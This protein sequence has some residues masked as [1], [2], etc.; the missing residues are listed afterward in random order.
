MKF[1]GE[2]FVPGIT[3]Q[4]LVDEHVDRYEFASQFAKNKKVLDIACGTGYGS[5]LLSESAESVIG[6]DVS[7]KSIEYAKSRFKKENTEFIEAPAQSD[8]FPGNSF[9]LIVSFETIEHL[10]EV[11]RAAYLSNLRRWL[12]RDGLLILS[13]PNKKIVSPFRDKPINQFHVL[14][15]SC[16]EL[17][18]ELS[19]YFKIQKIYG[20]RLIKKIFSKWIVWRSIT[21]LQRFFRLGQGIYTIANGSKISEYDPNKFE[22]RIFVMLCNRLEL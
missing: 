12:K 6:V 4:R 7:E 14:E 16:Q 20:Q 8:L 5:D 22:P 1:T 15:F 9:D 2:Q 17:A 19:P 13:T 18:G 11:A 3:K 21:L 10:N